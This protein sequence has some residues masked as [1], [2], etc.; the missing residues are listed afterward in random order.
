MYD[1]QIDKW[2]IV[3]I[4]TQNQNNFIFNSIF[5][6]QITATFNIPRYDFGIGTL[7]NWIYIAGGKGGRLALDDVQRVNVIDGTIENLTPFGEK[8][9]FVDAVMIR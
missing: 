9:K 6:E 1:E 3:R 4:Y 5:V 7:S 2:T 8:T